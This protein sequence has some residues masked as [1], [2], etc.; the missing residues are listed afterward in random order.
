VAV[1]GF[2]NVGVNGEQRQLLGRLARLVEHQMGVLERLAHAAFRCEVAGDHFGS[3][4][5]HAL[6]GRGRGV[7]DFQKS[8]RIEAEPFGKRYTVEP[9]NEVDR[10]LGTATIAHRADVMLALA[11][12]Q[13]IEHGA[14]SAAISASPQIRPTPSSF[15]V[16]LRKSSCTAPRD[17]TQRQRAVYSNLLL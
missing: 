16:R 11:R 9:E 3:L 13:R 14:A 6:R 7:C 12:E 5:V 10:E 2:E 17:L 1:A 15:E 4:G 8:R